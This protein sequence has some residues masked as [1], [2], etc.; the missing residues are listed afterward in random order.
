[1]AGR[2]MIRD[3]GRWAKRA[4][5]RALRAASG[6]RS[7]YNSL[8]NQREIWH[9]RVRLDSFPR[10]IQ[11]G[12]NWSC[13]LRCYFCRR[14]TEAERRRLS[15]LAPDQREIPEPAMERLMTAMPFAEIF[16]LTPLGEPLLY[17]GLD[18][19][20]E[21]YRSARC[22]NLQIT[23]NGVAMSEHRA[24]QLVECQVRRIYF[25]IDTADPETYAE[26]RVGGSLDEVTEGL[27]RLNDW[28]GRLSAQLPETIIAATFLRRN[29]EH[30]AG[31]VEYAGANQVGKISVQLMEAEEPS[32][33]PET[34]TH[35]VALTVASLKQA[36]QVAR[37]SGVELVIHMALANLLSAHATDEGVADLMQSRPDLDTRG[38]SLIDKC[39][40]PWTFLIVD[41]DGD[42]RPCC[43]TGLSYGNLAEKT[44]DQVWNG[45]AA[46][47]MRRDFLSGA[48]P[49][50]CHGRHC[51]VDL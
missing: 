19:L 6:R 24:R 49:A 13:N 36:Q 42:V 1:M 51:R 35:Y 4:R 18:S 38:K 22:R 28:K 43:W 27:A 15:S 40:Y 41:T 3:L 11:V 26:M 32:L 20:L 31:L 14:E 12:T 47:Q 10:E 9:G 33:E 39:A 2:P 34:L 46:Q 25:S 21:R 30:L 23:T 50:A 45:D 29:I 48:I 5:L 44:F 7:H 37:S 8:L 16:T 17:S